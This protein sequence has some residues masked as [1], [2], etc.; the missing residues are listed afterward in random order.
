[1][2]KKVAF[3]TILLAAVLNAV[4]YKTNLVANGDFS[5]PLNPTWYGGNF[6]GGEGRMFTSRDA[7]GNPFI[8]LEKTKG[9][10]GVQALSRVASLCGAKRFRFS[11]RYRRNGGLLYLRYRTHNG[12]KW[13]PIKGPTGQDVSL[14]IHDLKTTSSEKDEWFTYERIVKVPK[15]VLD[16]SPGFMIQFQTYSQKDGGTGF[17]EV[18]DMKI[19]PLEV[20]AEKE[21]PRVSLKVR[22]EPIKNIY[23]PVEKEFPFKWEIKNGLFYRNG[24][25]YFFCGWGDSTGGGMEG[26][27]GLWLAR[28]QGIRFIGTY[29]EPKTKVKKITEDSYEISANHSHGWISW[30]RESARFGMLT[31]PHPLHSYSKKSTLGNFTKSHP[32]WS[33]V[34][35]DLGH[36]VSI[37]AGNSVGRNILCE[38]RRQYF[39]YTY[40]NSGTDYC[41]LAREPG[42]ENCNERML[43]AF[44]QYAQTKYGNDLSLLNK[45]WGTSFDSWDSIIP[46]HLDKDALAATSQRLLLRRYV[47]NKYPA[48]Y[49]DFLRFMQLDTAYRTRNEFEDIR[50]AVKGV[51]VTIDMRAHHAYT[52]GYCAFDPELIAPLEDI[53][54]V[55]NS[56]AAKTY[57]STPWHEPTL[58]D[59]TAYPFFAY[60]YMTRN[61]TKPVVQAEDIVS[62]A[63]LPGSNADAMAENDFAKLHKRNWKFK[64]EASGEDG[65]ASGWQKKGFDDSSWGDIKVPGAWDDQAAYKGKTGVGWYRVR[66]NLEKRL[67]NDY[68]DTSRRFLIYGKGVAQKG[69]LWLNGEKVGEVKG[70]DTKYSF[71]VGAL[72]NYG[73]EN[74]I[75]WRVV[76]DNYKNGLRFYCHVLCS[77]MLN[78]SKPFGEKQFAQMYWT[79]MMRGTSAVLNW[80]W[81]DDALMPYLPKIITPIETAAAIALEPIRSRRSKVAYLFGFLSERGLPFPAE[82]RHHI[83][84]KWYN[85]L[86]FLGRRADIVSEKTFVREVTPDKYPLLVVPETYFV[87]DETYAHFKKYIEMGG[88]AVITTNALR[89]TYARYTPT[90][91]DSLTK[92]ITRLPADMPMV[93][94]MEKLKPILPERDTDQDFDVVS[95]EKRE[96]PLIE[97]L[98]AGGEKSK[99]LYLNNWGGYD[100]PLKVSL[101]EAFNDWHLTPLRGEFKREGA[102]LSVVVPSQDVATCLLTKDMPEPWMKTKP[103]SANDR[104]WKRVLELNSGVDTEKPNVLWAGDRHLYPYLLDR[105]A[106]YGFDNIEPCKVEEWTEE[107]LKSAK[108]IVIAESATRRLEKA[109]KNKEFIKMLKKWVEDGGSLYVSAFSAGTINAYGNVLRSIAG[110][111]K[112]HGSWMSIAKDETNAGLGDPWQILS[113]DIGKA[114]PLTEGVTHVQLFALTPMKKGRTSSIVPVVR[115]PSNASSHTGELAMAAVEYGKGRVFISADSMFCQPLRI[116]LADNAKLL[117]NIIGWLA[118]KKVTKEKRDEFK[119]NGLFL[120]KEVFF[121]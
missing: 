1:M 45:I 9:P 60:G 83:T 93:E 102:K 27:V 10:G 88:R 106:A 24:R 46:L 73:G 32:E 98:L 28:L 48:H 4:A 96:V 65:L 89:M 112:L 81:G 25:P 18:D 33:E 31:E 121:D 36:Y 52:D 79:Y 100:H 97:R 105:F 64:L 38:M 101:P 61:T 63:N 109:L 29:L 39:S 55:H 108:I 37:D 75:V 117:E 59:Q 70:W 111:F 20:E 2:K 76:G 71:D 103:S 113:S 90:D 13:Q 118:R 15:I 69:T 6:A 94:L 114:S 57:N 91:I 74:E 104:A 53:C 120:N 23:S 66:F 86:E 95:S 85:A 40:P 87:D 68:L 80:R 44:R 12:K 107:T 41:E 8:R 62:K 17:F 16:K 47:R 21:V 43:K 116:E 49:Y 42:I 5:L 78:S 51:P 19:E 35:F 26:A 30:Q 84:M 58:A 14:T 3:C 99:V 11:M 50:S 67:R 119:S 72:L 56:Y 22:M 34:Y 77:D 92:N 54:H 110:E 115:I 7:T 82:G